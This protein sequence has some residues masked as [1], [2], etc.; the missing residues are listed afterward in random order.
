M[1]EKIM[2]EDLPFELKLMFATKSVS[3]ENPMKYIDLMYKTV[4]PE[5]MK[6][7][8]KDIRSV[9]SKENK[10]NGK[11]YD[12]FMTL[13]G[14]GMNRSLFEGAIG[15][16]LW[17]QDYVDRAK[18]VKKIDENEVEIFKKVLRAI[19]LPTV[20]DENGSSCR[21]YAYFLA[22]YVRWLTSGVNAVKM[23]N[24]MRSNMELSRYLTA[25]GMNSFPALPFTSY[26]VGTVKHDDQMILTEKISKSFNFNDY[27][28]KVSRELN[29]PKFVVV[30][31]NTP[32]VGIPGHPL[33][34]LI[35]GELKNDNVE[36]LGAFVS[37]DEFSRICLEQGLTTKEVLNYIYTVSPEAH[38]AKLSKGDPIS[39]FIENQY[40]GKQI[41]E[42]RHKIY[43][44]EKIDEDEID[45]LLK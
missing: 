10:R 42:L 1:S 4:N 17:L 45:E 30:P 11:P 23:K 24:R 15:S 6:L 28:S 5:A 9:I 38:T 35:L 8:V 34:N 33:A 16:L 32:L 36:W 18:V 27:M 29:D 41:F 25:T 39:K 31:E 13:G 37:N 40:L 19:D 44:V 3:D 12:V 26:Y 2:Y 20:H 21:H 14:D 43:S 22:D 7:A